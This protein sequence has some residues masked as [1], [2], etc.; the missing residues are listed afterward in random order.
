MTLDEMI[1]QKR[2][3]GFSCRIIAERSG[4][5]LAT[6]QKIFSRNSKAP[7]EATLK[8]LETAFMGRDTY[9]SRQDF[10]GS[11][12]DGYTHRSV[13]GVRESGAVYLSVNG[14][15][16]VEEYYALPE[17]NR[18]E[19]IDGVFYDMASP[20][21]V[22]QQLVMLLGSS[23]HSF[24][25]SKKGNCLSM[26]APIDVQLDG[27]DSTMV[28]PDVLVLCD[29][30]KLKNGS[31]ISG[32]TDL[33]IEILSPSTKRKDMYLK[34]NKY[35]QAGVREYWMVDPDRESIVVYNFE[36]DDLV[37]VYHFD[38]MVPVGIFGGECRLDFSEFRE[39]LA[40]LRE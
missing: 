27:N 30:S 25:R 39:E 2:Q 28:Q 35:R 6:V 8:K 13:P 18:V 15:H 37:T 17:E 31:V 23:L 9:V 7:R 3:C 4:V 21:F 19:L 38:D 40:R 10:S 32:A 5:P 22:H 34:L 33:V 1:E 16:T 11:A 36:Q 24:I 26:I 12:A 20:T 14:R 29:H